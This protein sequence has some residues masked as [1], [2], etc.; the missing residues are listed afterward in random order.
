[1]DGH[2]KEKVPEKEIRDVPS[3][4]KK[5]HAQMIGKKFFDSGGPDKTSGEHFKPGVFTVLCY[6][7]GTRGTTPNYWCERENDTIEMKR[8]I[9]EF[10]C[11]FVKRM[12]EKYEKNGGCEK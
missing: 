6:Q 8:D 11:K 4:E 9:V 3:R 10:D 5:R 2:P 1:M 12:V 7:P